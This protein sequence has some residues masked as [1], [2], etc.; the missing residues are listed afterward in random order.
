MGG[1]QVLERDVNAGEIVVPEGMLFVLGEN[2]DN[3]LDSR[4]WGFVPEDAVIGLPWLVYWS[5][6]AQASKTRW[7]RTLRS[8]RN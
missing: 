5:Y 7:D 3:S 1:Q 6:D 2:R 4:Y 8:L